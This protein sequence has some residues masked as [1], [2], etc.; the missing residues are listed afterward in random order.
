MP[1]VG[2][3]N[4]LVVSLVVDPAA[5]PLGFTVARAGAPASNSGQP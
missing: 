1:E 2:F 3:I 4:L 5:A